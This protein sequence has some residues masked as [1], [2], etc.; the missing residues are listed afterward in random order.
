MKVLLIQ[1]Q[2]LIR[3]GL[4]QVLGRLLGP[5]G[6]GETESSKGALPLIQ[7]GWDLV[8][9]DVALLDSTG[10]EVINLTQNKRPKVPVLVLGVHSEDHYARWALRA[11]AAGYITKDSPLEE[12]A[13]AVRTTL[14]GR[15]Y[16]CPALA[17]RLAQ[18]WTSDRT[19]TPHE[20]LS[21]RELQVLRLMASGKTVTAIASELGLSVKTISTHRARIL[22]KMG[23]KTNSE[24][25]RYALQ[26]RLVD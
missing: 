15:R 13:K 3:E 6:F 21:R 12:I 9:V 24:L 4:K 11:G 17:E 22:E 16:V 20:L 8:I 10:L 7:K 18:D 1:H 25:I 2:L 26:S 14:A 23:M 5:A 19:R